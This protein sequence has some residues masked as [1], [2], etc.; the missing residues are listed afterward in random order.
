MADNN[1]AQTKYYRT[2]IAGLS[3]QIGDAPSDEEKERGTVAPPT[4]RFE[5]Y[6]EKRQ[7]DKVVVGYLATDNLV[8]IRKLAKDGNVEEIQKKDFDEATDLEK[9]AKRATV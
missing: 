3:V 4:V 5:A 6:E 9:G 7:G 1:S 2:H 8:A